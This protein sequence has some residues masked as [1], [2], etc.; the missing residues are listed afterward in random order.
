MTCENENEC[1][2]SNG[3]CAQL[4][5]D[6]PGSYTCGCLPG[7]RLSANG[8]FLNWTRGIQLRAKSQMFNDTATISKLEIGSRLYIRKKRVDLDSFLVNIFFSV[9][10]LNDMGAKLQI[11]AKTS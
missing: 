10:S 8:K 9:F 2:N 6:H 3:G 7:Y 5:F 11:A 4:C 1:L